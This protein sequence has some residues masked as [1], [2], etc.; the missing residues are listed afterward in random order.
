MNVHSHPSLAVES[1]ESAAHVLPLR[2]LSSLDHVLLH[3][4]TKE[5]DPDVLS[6]QLFRRTRTERLG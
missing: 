5:L 6:L 1:R 4:A 2:M 3:R